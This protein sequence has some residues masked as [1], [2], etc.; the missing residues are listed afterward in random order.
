M[1]CLESRP[2][3]LEQCSAALSLTIGRLSVRHCAGASPEA[4]GAPSG[5]QCRNQG[6]WHEVGGLTWAESLQRG[7]GYPYGQPRSQVNLWGVEMAV[8]ALGGEANPLCSHAPKTRFPSQRLSL[9]PV[10]LLS[11]P[12]PADCTSPSAVAASEDPRTLVIGYRALQ[13]PPS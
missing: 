8:R 6:G 5:S 9:C 10:A 4:S 7:P 1:S 11:S 12:P 2:Q 13:A 3:I